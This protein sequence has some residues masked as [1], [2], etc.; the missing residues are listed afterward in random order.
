MS[1][2]DL[3][4]YLESNIGFPVRSR[5]MFG[6]IGFFSDDTTFAIIYDGVLYLKSSPEIVKDYTEDSVQFEPPFRRRKGLSYWSIQEE[7]LLDGERL[8]QW[9][10]RSLDYAKRTKRDK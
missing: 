1:D 4:D 7:I 2:T 9:A 5:K 8:A 6:G 10:K 3:L